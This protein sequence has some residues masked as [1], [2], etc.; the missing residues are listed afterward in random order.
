[1]ICP[2]RRNCMSCKESNHLQC[3]ILK[4]WFLAQQEPSVRSH[5]SK[6]VEN[7]ITMRR[8]NR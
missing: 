1:M 5:A 3:E 8:N 4:N 6:L 7:D 2:L